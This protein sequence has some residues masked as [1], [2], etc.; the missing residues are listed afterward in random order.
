[1]KTYDI[2]FSNGDYSY[3][4][5]VLWT[6]EEAKAY[7]RNNGTNN[8]YFADYNGDVVSVVCNE[9]GETVYAETLK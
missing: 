9:T 8:G 7:V 2:H 4:M 5:G 6:I 3:S 1:M